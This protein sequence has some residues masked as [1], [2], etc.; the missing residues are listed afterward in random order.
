L[1]RLRLPKL[2]FLAHRGGEAA[3]VSQKMIYME[4]LSA[5]ARPARGLKAWATFTKPTC[6][7]YSIV[8]FTFITLRADGFSYN[9]VHLNQSAQ[10][11]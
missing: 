4:R 10:I 11:G 3:A 2:F 7:G 9:R 6:V 1:G 5:T 8:F